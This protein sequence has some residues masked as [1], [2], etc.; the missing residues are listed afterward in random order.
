MCVICGSMKNREA[1]H[2]ANGSHHPQLRFEV[3]NGVTLCRE[4]HTA[5]HTDYKNSFR[6]KTT[7]KDWFNFKKLVDY[8]RG[9]NV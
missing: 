2:I 5:F 4:C 1:H 6:E 9:L 3:S 7:K 8:I